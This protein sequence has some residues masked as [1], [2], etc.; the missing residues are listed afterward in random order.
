ML[1]IELCGWDLECEMV[2]FGGIMVWYNVVGCFDII[3]CVVVVKD[4]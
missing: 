3:V 4:K 1:G 2:V